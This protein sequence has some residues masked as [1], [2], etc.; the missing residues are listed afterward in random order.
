MA[1]TQMIWNAPFVL[2]VLFFKN[3]YFRRISHLDRNV[4]YQ[5][6][7]NIDGIREISFASLFANSKPN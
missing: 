7:R 6:I 4:L 2:T 1:L 5:I 3:R